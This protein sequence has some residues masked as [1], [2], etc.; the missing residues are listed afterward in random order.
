M[1]TDRHSALSSQRA[2]PIKASMRAIAACAGVGGAAGADPVVELQ[3][4]KIA[5]ARAARQGFGIR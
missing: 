4:T 1:A 3:P 5:K 2:S